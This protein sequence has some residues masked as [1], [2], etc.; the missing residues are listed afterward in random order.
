MHGRERLANTGVVAGTQLEHL[1]QE[2]DAFAHRSGARERTEVAMLAIQPAAV[3][4]QLRIRVAGQA[5]V[6]VALV[7]AVE[8]VVA[9]L[10]RLDQVVLE[11]QRLAF[12]ARHRGLDAGDLRDHR[13]DPRTSW[14]VFWK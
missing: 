5:D 6:G 12:R 10:V 2:R 1:L 14:P 13:R 11:Q 8:D 7:V 3:E 4:A 9:R